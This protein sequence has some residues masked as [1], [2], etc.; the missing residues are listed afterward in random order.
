[1]VAEVIQLSGAGV[2]MK[3]TSLLRFPVVFV[4]SLAMLLSLVVAALGA[5]DSAGLPRDAGDVFSGL[6]VGFVAS[7]YFLVLSGYLAAFL[8]TYFAFARKV[9]V[10]QRRWISLGLF[11]VAYAV[12]FVLMGDSFSVRESYLLVAG[13]ISVVI[14]DLI[15][16]SLEQ[17]DQTASKETGS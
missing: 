2:Q 11:V 4:I 6:R 1:M 13:S 17:R 10:K 8:V 12:F 9:G 3:P 16:E 15:A 5:V 7:V 14:S